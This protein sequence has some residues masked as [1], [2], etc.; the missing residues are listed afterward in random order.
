M[1]VTTRFATFDPLQGRSTDYDSVMTHFETGSHMPRV[2][3]ATKMDSRKSVFQGFR[4]EHFPSDKP[5]TNGG[6]CTV[7]CTIGIRQLQLTHSVFTHHRLPVPA[8]HATACFY[9][10]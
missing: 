7:C 1:Y 5:E 4:R 8:T 10:Y 3:K 6:Y 9:S 2:D